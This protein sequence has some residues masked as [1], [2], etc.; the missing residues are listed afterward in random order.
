MLEP[1]VL[2]E[3]TDFAL[4]IFLLGLRRKLLVEITD[5]ALDIV[6]LVLRR[7]TMVHSLTS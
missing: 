1:P 6:L 3:A 4:E 5:L 2:A 7:K